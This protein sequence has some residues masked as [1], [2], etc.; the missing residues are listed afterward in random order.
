MSLR[1]HG[2]TLSW[3]AMARRSFFTSTELFAIKVLFS[4][5]VTLSTQTTTIIR[6]PSARCAPHSQVADM[7]TTHAELRTRLC[8]QQLFRLHACWPTMKQRK[9]HCH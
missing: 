5:L 8:M 9:P 1:M 2:I 3:Y 7:Q 4:P 6:G